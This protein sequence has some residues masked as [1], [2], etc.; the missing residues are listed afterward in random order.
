MKVLQVIDSLSLGGSESLAATLAEQVSRRGVGCH[1]C[2]LGAD[3][4]LRNRLKSAGIGFSHLDAR[5]G[6]KPSA[7]FALMRLVWRESTNIILTHHFR[8]LVHATPAAFLLRRRLVHVEHDFHSYVDRPDILKRFAQLAPIVHRFVFVSEPIRALFADRLP[9]LAGKSVAIPNGVDTDRFQPAPE[10]RGRIRELVGAEPDDFLVGTCARLEPIKDIPLLLEGFARLSQRINDAG[11]TARLVL[12]GD[13]SQRQELEKQ[14]AT[15]GICDRC[16]FAGAVDNVHDWLSG[17]D[18]YAITS[19]DEGLPLSVMEAM[20][21]KL[22]VV[23]VNVGSLANIVD[24]QVG[25]LLKSRSPDDLGDRLVTLA[26]ATA[27]SK[28]LGEAARSKVVKAYSVNSM[29]ESYLGIMGLSKIGPK[30]T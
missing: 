20:S 3:G 4:P 1:I 21:C 27:L 6:V 14:A 25:F 23:A 2:G 8:Q 10:S 12:V 7:M 28:R 26:E 19:I 24:D 9:R 29:V 5:S 18:A 22:P 16:H 15:L 11:R 30:R 17:M 13:G